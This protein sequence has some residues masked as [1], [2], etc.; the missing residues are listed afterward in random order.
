MVKEDGTSILWKPANVVLSTK[1]LGCEVKVAGGITSLWLF[2]D[3]LVIFCLRRVQ[4]KAIM[5]GE[6]VLRSSTL[7]SLQGESYHILTERDE[8]RS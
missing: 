2:Q 8:Q 1:E 6:L 7:V 3:V 5:K 4:N